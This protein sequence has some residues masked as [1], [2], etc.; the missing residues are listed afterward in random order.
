MK[1]VGEDTLE[2]IEVLIKKLNKKFE[3]F[4]NQGEI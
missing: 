3:T 2:E 4:W 1:K